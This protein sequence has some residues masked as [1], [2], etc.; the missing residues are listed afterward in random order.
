VAGA[1]EVVERF[2]TAMA[3][4]D[5]S[6]MGSCVTEDVRRVGPYGDTYNGRA[7]YVRFIS[8]LLPTLPGYR[9]D[10]ARVV[11]AGGDRVVLAEL[12]ETVE[13]DGA[14]LETPEGLVFDLDDGGLISHISI[15]IRRP[16]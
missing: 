2:L 10:I 4:H 8:E 1:T 5:W 11:A 16:G 3:D 14:P 13:V 9:M 6:T 7:H 15:Y 12:S